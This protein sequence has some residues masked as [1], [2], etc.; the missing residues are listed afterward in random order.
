MEDAGYLGEAYSLAVADP[1]LD[2][3]IGTIAEPQGRCTALNVG[4][5]VRQWWND[6]GDG[7]TPA[8][9]M[10]A[11]FPGLSL[12]ETIEDSKRTVA[13]RQQQV[14]LLQD[15]L[16]SYWSRLGAVSYLPGHDEKVLPG[17]L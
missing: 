7:P 16:I 12:I 1:F 6:R 8:E 15:W 4:E 3:L 10:S 17:S 14:T 5:V 2:A 13:H 9:L 11:V